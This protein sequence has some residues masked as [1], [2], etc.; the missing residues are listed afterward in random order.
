[1]EAFTIR[2]LLDHGKTVEIH[3]PA[4][5]T[6][7]TTDAIVRTA[8]RPRGQ[9]FVHGELW[10]AEADA[11]VPVGREVVVDRVDGLTLRVSPT[12]PEGATT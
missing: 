11:E 6:E 4:D 12:T 7:E 9:V 10:Q 2:L 8:L 5:I 1:M 3:G